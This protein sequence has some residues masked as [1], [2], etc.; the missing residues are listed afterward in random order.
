MSETA[1]LS[2]IQ[3]QIQ[4]YDPTNFP[5]WRKVVNGTIRVIFWIISKLFYRLKVKGLDHI[6]ETGPA[7]IVS[8][9][10]SW[11]DGILMVF[12]C[13]RPI[14]MLTYG[15]FVEKGV[16]G[17]IARSFGAIP[18]RDS[19]GPKALLRSMKIATDALKKGQ[20]VGIFAE[21]QLTRT[22]QTFPFQAG[23]LRILRGTEAPVVPCHIDQLWGSLFSFRGGKFFWKFPRHMPY[24]ITMNFGKPISSPESVQCIS[25]AVH[26]LGVQSLE[27][28]KDRLMI[29]VRRF[30]RKCRQARFRSKVADSSGLELSG[31]NLL[32]G[33]LVMKTLLK[34]HALAAEDDMVGVLLPPT[35]AAVLTNAAISLSGR[36]AVNLNYTLD[37]K[38]VNYCIKEAGIQK[39]LTSRKFLEKRPYNL[40]AEVILLED[41]KPKASG[42]SKLLALLTAHLVPLFLLERIYGLNNISPDEVMTIIFTS[43]STGEPKGVML[44]HSNIMTN[45]DAVDQLLHIKKEDVLLGVLPFFHCF[46][47]TGTMWLTLCLSPKTVYHINPLDARMVGKLAK[48]H[49]VTVIMA[50]PTFLRTY[51]KRCTPEQFE[52]LNLVIVGAEKMPLDL[53]ENFKEKF[54]VAP[55]EGYGTTEL[56]PVAA[57]NVPPERSGSDLQKG[58]KLGTVGRVIPGVMAKIVHLETGEDLPYGEP[59]LLMIKGSN[60]MK[61]YLNKP[62]KTAEVLQDG[63]YNTGDCAFIDEEGFIAITG[64][65]SRFSKIGGEMVPHIKIEELLQ[66]IVENPEEQEAE[67]EAAMKIAVTSV[68]DE[69]KGEKVVVLHK[70]LTRSVDEILEEMSKHD[71]PNLWIPNRDNFIEVEAIPLLGTGKLD[72]QGMKQVALA[73]FL[74]EPS[75]ANS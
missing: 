26:A 66:G 63:W 12:V 14:R 39:V 43:G 2:P 58:T 27:D 20:L 74:P 35:V 30:L 13:R 11:L 44:T 6:P 55:T 21:G 5:L 8:N 75:Q 17:W 36:K 19:D 73:H 10:V 1:N 40:D 41:L 3:R 69:K 71:I 4:E 38:T 32:T 70:G 68:P 45:I 24:P 42:L 72:L 65:Q 49:Q 28:R 54:G 16:G 56:S 23:M 57:F 33:A 15:D 60:V 61:G 53:Y 25:H 29:P 9:H 31:G 47:Y 22:G 67:E 52:K 51:M 48:K 46:G 37:E 50:T 18:I 64:R 34:Q 7:L 59:G 62:E